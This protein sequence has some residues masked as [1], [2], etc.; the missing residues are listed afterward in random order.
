MPPPSVKSGMVPNPW[1]ISVIH[2]STPAVAAIKPDMVV[3]A[4]KRCPRVIG[5]P[6]AGHVGSLDIASMPSGNDTRS[7]ALAHHR[8]PTPH[9]VLNVHAAPIDGA[10]RSVRTNVCR[11]SAPKRNI[12]ARRSAAAHV[13]STGGRWATP[14]GSG[15]S[16][17]R[18]RASTRC[19]SRTTTRCSRTSARCCSRAAARRRMAGC[20]SRA[21][22]RGCMTCRC[23]RSAASRRMARCRTRS[24]ASRR[25][26]RR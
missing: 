4:V 3:P 21:T 14:C 6:S 9:S 26:T 23:T 25:M 17:R 20:R 5:M 18:S 2:M 19:R 24:A 7:I 11:S 15:T 22:R 10:N 16:A 13:A 8:A 1:V 12:P